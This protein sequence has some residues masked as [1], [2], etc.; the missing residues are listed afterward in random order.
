MP[1]CDDW[2]SYRILTSGQQKENDKQRKN[3][4]AGEDLYGK[5]HLR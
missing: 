2:S 4:E 3:K 5:I 1:T